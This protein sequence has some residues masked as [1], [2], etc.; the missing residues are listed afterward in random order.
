MNLHRKQIFLVS[1]LMALVMVLSAC[2]DDGL[3]DEP[4]VVTEDVVVGGET[5]VEVVEETPV[6]VG[7]D[8]V[9]AD[10]DAEADVE[11]DAE[12]ATDVETETSTEVEAEV[13][14]DT[15]VVTQTEVFTETDI[16][17][18]I[19]ETEVI[20]DVN[21]I[22]DTE[23]V[24]D[25]A[26]ETEQADVDTTAAVVLIIFTD[27]EGNRFLADEAGVPIFAYTG[28][29][30]APVATEEFQPL[31]ETDQVI[32]GE[33]LDETMFLVNP[34]SDI[35]QWTYNELPLYRYI[36]TDDPLTVAPDYELAPLAVEE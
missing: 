34:E 22:T 16:T 26:V 21:V 8:V 19:T 25:S 31:T 12:T 11:A 6:A 18:V 9:D 32:F 23:T 35:G 2:G 3:T 13:I 7:E 14:V 30:T 17:E 24:Q 27:A 15:D 1:I 20:T 36:G 29:D 5:D 28:T 4:E 10:V 33:G